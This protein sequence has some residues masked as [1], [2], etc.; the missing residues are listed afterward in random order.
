MS[1][2]IAA[3]TILALSLTFATPL[4]ASDHPF[5]KLLVP[6]IV[7]NPLPG[8]F[9][10]QFVTRLMVHND[11]DQPVRVDQ[12]GGSF[13]PILGCF[14]WVPPGIH[15]LNAWAPPG[16]GAFIW[17]DTAQMHHLSFQVRVQDLSRQE[18]TWGTELPILRESD[19]FDD[20]LTLIDVP[21]TE[22]FRQTLRVYE[23]DKTPN[24]L[25][26]VR[27]YDQ[28]SGAL[29]RELPVP[30][31]RFSTSAT[32]ADQAQVAFWTDDFADLRP[33][34]RLRIVIE[35]VTPGIRFW[36]FVSIT[37]NETQH[38]TTITPLKLRP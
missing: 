26:M 31:E 7:P 18:S 25:V 15:Q 19:F 8:A 37:H 16:N 2:R 10:S 12:S 21:D 34:E 38:I 33:A 23:W 1:K 5:E 29:L 14:N 13:C 35:P 4:H 36:A 20:R 22:S 6:L 17:V 3:F 9:G 32:D 27:F 11:R 30:L 24:A 28:E